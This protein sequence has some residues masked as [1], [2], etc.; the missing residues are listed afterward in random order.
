MTDRPYPAHWEADV[1]LLDGRTAHLRPIRPDDG[2][3]LL[4]FYAGVSDD[5]KYMRF[6]APRPTLTPREVEHLTSV[7]FVHR[8]AFIALLGE[9]MV[10]V[11]RYEVVRSTP[12]R[13]A[14]VAFLVQDA[15][16]GRGVGSV[17]LEHLAAAARERGVE[18]FV[19]DVLPANRRMVGVFR[20]A[21]YALNRSYD[22][23]VITLVFDV[24][25]TETSLAVQQAREH[26]AEAR[27]VETVLGPDSVAVVGAS[28][29][30]HSV[31]QTVLRH[32]LAAGFAGRL[33][34]VHPEAAEVAGVPA[35]P[36]LAAVPGPVDLAVVAVPAEAVESVV[37]DAAA[38]SVRGLLV[39]SG[40][41]AETG[42][43]GR[44]RQDRLVRIARAHGMRVIGPTS[45]GVLNTAPGTWLNASLSPVMPPCGP[46]GFFSQSGALGAAILEA[47]TA[48]GLGLSTFVSAGNRADVSGNDVLQYW[49]DDPATEAVLLHLESI[50]NP[51]KFTRLARRV[52]RVKPIVAV[53][54][55][56][57]TQGV[58]LGHAVRASRA[59]AAAVDALFRQ[60]GVVRV[61][62]MPRL[63]DTAQVLVNQPLPGGRRISV[64]ANSA[65]LGLLAAD[66]AV[67]AGLQVVGEPLALRADAT[68]GEYERAL[69]AA[70]EDP[71]VDS[72]VAVFLPPLLTPDEDVAR[73]LAA[74]GARGAK[75][76]VSSFL[77]RR[78]VDLRHLADG[79]SHLSGPVLDPEG[80]PP[81]TRAREHPAGTGR[82]L[83]QGDSPAGGAPAALLP[84]RP[85][86]PSYATPEDAVR[87]LA[88]VSE[89]AEWVRR[90]L[91]RVPEVDGLDP[92]RARALVDRA[93]A[94]RLEG[95]VLDEATTAELLGCYGITLSPS[96]PARTPEEAAVA[97][98]RLGYPVVLKTTAPG[99]RHRP[100]LGTVRLDIADEGELRAEWVAMRER[101]GAP[102]AS[103]LVV[104]RLASPGTAV[105]V[106]SMEDP[107]FGPIV[108]FGLGGVA[109][110]LLG[111]IAYRSPPLT[112][113]DVA[114]MVRSV[115][116][117]PMLFGYHGA[118]PADVA[119]VEDL[120]LRVSRLA[121]DLPEVADLELNPVLVGASGRGL[122]VVGATCTL[123]PPL[124]R[125]DGGPRALP[126]PAPRAAPVDA[127][128]LLP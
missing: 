32:L 111:D 73:V 112:D 82:C 100:E 90:P 118:D 102:V 108:S 56:R 9:E 58:P 87:A 105:V 81:R 123:S 42:Y 44:E 48:R 34:A 89:Y 76:V 113:V 33:H 20:D 29:E 64:L 8:V 101:L 109:T 66:A 2:D 7:D 104:Q 116:A 83:P 72:V 69:T 127:P 126:G 57:A 39:L 85:T 88:A 11:A 37:L 92:E 26:R 31:G 41:F 70:V 5:S 79:R 3:R 55:G 12:V 95:V 93:L 10:G 71:A 84:R 120:L 35:Y 65:A 78:S 103:S 80:S 46:L 59:P 36:S 61:D 110:Q 117:A 22:D 53:K 119:A 91:G 52:G 94:E 107:L 114:E 38:R 67:A 21:G 40:G 77:A 17:L 23:G 96:E 97:A 106:S 51:R 43:A 50:G 15:H 16:Q 62:D 4:R 63:L 1:V 28:R 30:P 128:S 18:R 86:V 14:E 47:V 68:A 6:F 99:L 60:A 25:Q 124:V 125:T 49:E 45:F 27:S 19:A 122:A 54:S 75:T 98:A 13:T 121:D 74:I 24:A 115:R